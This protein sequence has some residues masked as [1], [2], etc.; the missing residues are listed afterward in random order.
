MQRFISTDGNRVF[1]DSPEPL[2][3]EDG[4]SRQDVYE[5]ERES[6]GSCT[7]GSGVNGGCVDLLS[8]GTSAASSWLLDASASGE[9]VFIA[10][11]AQLS[12]VDQNYAYD[13]Y[14]ARVGA[15]PAGRARGVAPHAQHLPAATLAA[16]ELLRPGEHRLC[17]DGQ[18]PAG[19]GGGSRDRGQAE[20]ADA[21]AEARA[22]AEGDE[23]LKKQRKRAVVQ[24]A[25]ASQVRPGEEGEA[26]RSSYA[27][28]RVLA[29]TIACFLAAFISAPAA[30]AEE[31]AAP[32]WRLTARSCYPTNLPPGGH[33]ILRI[34][35]YDIGAAPSSR[36]G[37]GHRHAASR[38]HRDPKPAAANSTRSCTNSDLQRHDRRQ[39]H[40]HRRRLPAID[41]GDSEGSIGVQSI[42]IAID[43]PGGS[44][45][46]PNQVTIS[47]GGAPRLRERVR[48]AER[49]LGA[50]RIWT[51]GLR[52]MV[53]QRRRDDRHTGR[54]A[55]IRADRA[56]RLQH[57]AAGRRTRTRG[58]GSQEHHGR[59]APGMIGD[60]QATPRCSASSS[61]PGAA[62]RTPRSGS[63][64]P[65]RAP[66][67]SHCPY[68]TSFPAPG[69]P[70][71]FGFT[72]AGISTF[73]DASVRSGGDYGITE[74]VEDLAQREVLFNSLDDVGVPPQNPA[75]TLCGVPPQL[76]GRLRIRRR[77]GAISDAPDSCGTPEAQAFTI[78]A[79]GCRAEK[80][81]LNVQM[82]PCSADRPGQPTLIRVEIDR[83][84][85]R[86]L[87]SAGFMSCNSVR[88]L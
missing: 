71:Q 46:A 76:P 86:S 37:H 87:E 30:H 11:R 51:R 15:C 47:G 52:R 38:R 41:P 31:T 13:V 66:N 88:P 73:L 74:H 48:A 82:R 84:T 67:H 26:M 40:E 34:D 24:A 8:G 70:A 28:A 72:L 45:A 39:M 36:D 21:R 9:D 64:R 44:P 43:V 18:P 4:N 83:D 78:A 50:R 59:A 56:A 2:V 29:L 1:F 23:K 77:T 49:Q 54:L 14:D 65:I 60:P 33:G 75:T 7:P 79:N 58:R 85:H 6:S 3:P 81:G 12:S 16:P 55:P 27:P 20:A 80:D 22:S 35:V 69:L 68:T 19:G 53:Q 42:A 32:G 10:T 57:H 61:T 62:P 17:G 25:G 5:W 63:I